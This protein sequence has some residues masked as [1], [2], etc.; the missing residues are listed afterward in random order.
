MNT[1]GHFLKQMKNTHI[2]VLF[3]IGMVVTVLGALFKI[4]HWPGAR[5]LL[6]IGMV[7]EAAAALFLILKLLKKDKDKTGFLDS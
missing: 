6:I 2:L 1:F 3:L 7:F 5:F 4:M